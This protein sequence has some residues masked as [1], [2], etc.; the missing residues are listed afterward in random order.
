MEANTGDAGLEAGTADSRLVAAGL[1]PVGVGRLC[2]VIF[3]YLRSRDPVVCEA[4]GAGCGPS[5]QV[6][7]G[8]KCC[9]GGRD[10]VGHY[11]NE[12]L[13]MGMGAA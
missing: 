11:G 12:S 13:S 6:W 7:K 2:C 10:S 9:S 5:A 1:R 8:P 4:L 3:S